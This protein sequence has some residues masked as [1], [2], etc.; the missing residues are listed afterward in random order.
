[1]RF[2]SDQIAKRACVVDKIVSLS[3]SPSDCSFLDA[4]WVLESNVLVK[5]NSFF[6]SARPDTQRAGWMF[7]YRKTSCRKR[8]A[9]CVQ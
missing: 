8:I 4:E 3:P 9:F 1:M 7:L 5:L 6:S 2:V